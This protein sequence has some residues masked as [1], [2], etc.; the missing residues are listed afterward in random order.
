MPNSILLQIFAA[1]PFPIDPKLT[2]FAPIKLRSDWAR[3]NVL[4]D[5]EPTMKV[6]VAFWAPGNCEKLEGK[7]NFKKNLFFVKFRSDFHNNNK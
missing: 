3:E 7:S 2:T 4:S 1:I 5:P 6:R